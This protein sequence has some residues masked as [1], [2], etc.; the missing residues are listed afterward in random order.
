MKDIFE[1]PPAKAL[2]APQLATLLSRVRAGELSL[3][4]GANPEKL[5]FGKATGKKGRMRVAVVIE[6]G[7]LSTHKLAIAELLKK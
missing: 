1:S 3:D 4:P 7:A 5:Y 6:R 2:T